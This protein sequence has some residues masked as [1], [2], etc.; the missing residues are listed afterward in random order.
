MSQDW[1]DRFAIYQ[2]TEEWPGEINY[3]LPQYCK[4]NYDGELTNWWVAPDKQDDI[5]FSLVTDEVFSKLFSTFGGFD[6]RREAH[7]SNGKWYVEVHSLVLD[8]FIGPQQLWFPMKKRRRQLI[9][10]HVS[11]YSTVK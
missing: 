9:Q 7:L 11:R 4:L 3:D 1:L 2:R 10:M 5:K 6:I 8:V